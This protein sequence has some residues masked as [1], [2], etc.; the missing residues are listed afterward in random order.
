VTGSDLVESKPDDGQ[1]TTESPF[2][3]DD[4]GVGLKISG[5]RFRGAE[6]RGGM[7]SGL[8]DGSSNS[9]YI[10]LCYVLQVGRVGK[11]RMAKETGE[12]DGSA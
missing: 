9:V 4:E 11:T 8:S 12:R 6:R 10:W 3:A 5:K 2:R 1:L 7:A